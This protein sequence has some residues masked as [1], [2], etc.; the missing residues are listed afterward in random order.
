MVILLNLMLG[1]MHPDVV[2]SIDCPGSF[3]DN[4][5]YDAWRSDT[6]MGY[7]ANRSERPDGYVLDQ[8]RQLE[9]GDA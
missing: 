9:S 3:N 7:S 6:T 4:F 2:S 8:L 1:L 5:P